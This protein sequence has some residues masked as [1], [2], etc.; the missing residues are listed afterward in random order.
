M[1]YLLIILFFIP[2]IVFSQDKVK[3]VAVGVTCSMCSNAIHKSL[4]MDKTIEKIEPNLETQEWVVKYKEGKFNK[5]SVKVLEKRVEDAGF[6]ISKL[7]IN[8][9]LIFDKN[10][11]RKNGN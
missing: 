10:K 3:F 9:E 6:S 11:K 7:W 8:D 1:K 5:E 4:S 2:M